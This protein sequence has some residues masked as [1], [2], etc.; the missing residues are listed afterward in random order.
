MRIPFRLVRR[1][2]PDP[3]FAFLIASVGVI[4][5]E[6]FAFYLLFSLFTLYL[7]TLNRI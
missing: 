2:I 6:R 3:R 7:L 5:I 4:A 1:P